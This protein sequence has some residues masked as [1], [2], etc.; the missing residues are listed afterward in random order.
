MPNHSSDKITVV[1]RITRFDDHVVDTRSTKDS[2]TEGMLYNMAI[3]LFPI[4]NG[5]IGD[6]AL[7]EY[8]EGSEVLFTIDR[9]VQNDNNEYIYDTETPYVMYVFANC[10]ALSKR[11]LCCWGNNQ[12]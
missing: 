8:K 11:R 12:I 6:C 5:E 3:A 2:E 1:G 7:F 9:Q 10:T 4:K